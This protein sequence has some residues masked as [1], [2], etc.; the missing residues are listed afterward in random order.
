M[1]I[2]I[3]D[4]KSSLIFRVEVADMNLVIRSQIHTDLASLLTPV[5]FY[6]VFHIQ[7]N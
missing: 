6:Y 3:D 7:L 2:T 5:N 1:K 4:K